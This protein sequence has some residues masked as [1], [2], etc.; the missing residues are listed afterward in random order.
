[1]LTYIAS[2]KTEIPG[3]TLQHILIKVMTKVFDAIPA[4][5]IQINWAHTTWKKRT[6]NSVMA[7]VATTASNGSP[8]VV[9]VQVEDAHLKPLKQVVADLHKAIV[10]FPKAPFLMY[11]P[12]IQALPAPLLRIGLLLLNQ[13]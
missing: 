12:L 13:L 8:A 3:L 10:D 11:S 9:S 2:R 1:M 7:T 5:A 6:R 4:A